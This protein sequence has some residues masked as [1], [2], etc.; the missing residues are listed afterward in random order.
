VQGLLDWLLTLPPA[1]LYG[2]L[3]LAAA[4]ENVFPPFPS[5]VVVAF[6]SF[7]AAQGKKSVTG[8]VLAVWIGNVS[9]AMLVYALGR[10]YGAHRLERRLAGRRA[11]AVD[12]RLRALFEKHGLVAVFLSRFVPAVRS[13]VPAFAGAIR[14]SA[15]LT[16]AMIAV[17]SGIWYGLIT[18]I[19]YRVGTDWEQLRDTVTRY[20]TIIGITAGVLLALG[21]GT[22]VVVRRPRAKT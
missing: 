2:V 7:V 11:E 3:A 5:D 12:A 19:A 10:R 14:L 8:V 4:I 17:A 18:V 16:F 1:A 20:S 6:A 13:V 21:I 22:W 15:W 9:T